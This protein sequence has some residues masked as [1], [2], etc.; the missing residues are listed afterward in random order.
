M[1]NRKK[2][3]RPRGSRTKPRAAAFCLPPTCPTCGR[4]VQ[5]NLNTR[6]ART[7]DHPGLLPDGTAYRRME[8]RHVECDCGQALAVRTPIT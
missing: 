4:T 2:P 3:G 5:V 6:P 8:W 7:L 1:G